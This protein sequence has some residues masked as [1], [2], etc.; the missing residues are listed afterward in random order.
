MKA[1]LQGAVDPRR[2]PTFFFF[3]RNLNNRENVYK[4]LET[5]ARETVNVTR[6]SET[7]D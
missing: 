4:C 5:D 6:D 2:F 7:E 1:G 3:W